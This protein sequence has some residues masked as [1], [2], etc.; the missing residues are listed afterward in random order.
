MDLHVATV[1]GSGKEGG[2]WTMRRGC[3]C[4]R[5]EIR[6]GEAP[7]IL[8]EEP[9]DESGGERRKVGRWGGERKVCRNLQE[10]DVE[11]LLKRRRR[12]RSKPFT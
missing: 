1:L 7:V 6:A 12:P 5:R 4:R 9:V 11:L 8:G 10:S 2:G 3:Y